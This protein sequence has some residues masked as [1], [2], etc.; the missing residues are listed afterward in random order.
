MWMC[1]FC[2]ALC[3][4]YHKKLIVVTVTGCEWQSLSTSWQLTSIKWWS[5]TLTSLLRKSLERVW[6]YYVINT[7][8][9]NFLF[10]HLLGNKDF[11]SLALFTRAIIVVFSM[12]W[13]HLHPHAHHKLF[14]D[15]KTFVAHIFWFLYVD[16]AEVNLIGQSFDNLARRSGRKGPRLWLSKQTWLQENNLTRNIEKKC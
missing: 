1:L 5:Y 9:N 15:K 14:F 8:W 7:D 6:L 11:C 13:S 4:V 16:T 10:C 3:S 12:V 2:C